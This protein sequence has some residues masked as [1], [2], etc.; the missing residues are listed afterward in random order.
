[1]KIVYSDDQRLHAPRY[2]MSAGDMSP[3]FE[4]PSRADMVLERVRSQNFGEVVGVQ[5]YSLDHI[6]RVHSESYVNFLQNCWCLW[7]K[8]FGPEKDAMPEVF[9]HRGMRQYEPESIEAK[10]GYYAFDVCVGI[11]SG[12]WTAIKTAADVALTGVDIIADGER[13]AFSLC[14]PPGHHASEDLMGGYC[15]INNAAVAAQALRD[16]GFNKVAILDVDYHHGNGTQSIFY[17]RDDIYFAS[18]HGDPEHEYPY[19]LGYADETG[20]AAGAGYNLN[21][22]LPLG[23]T[24]WGNYKEALNQCMQAIKDFGADVI[25]V[26]LGLDTFENDP[27]SSFKI[28][29]D[30]FFEMGALIEA[31]VLPTLFVFEGGYGL[32]ALGVNAVNVLQG[33]ER[34]PST[35]R[36]FC[37]RS[38]SG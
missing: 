6:T 17:A 4:K 29:S 5:R 35:R 14:R 16:K 38:R 22:P 10:L 18:I 3:C 24:D 34:S 32:E 28:R 19:Y 31:A 11:T 12:S 9:P 37:S 13:S 8:K 21:L 23:T 33:F 26:S 25:V 2:Q 36:E 27:I 20:E 1:M 30:E 15:Y 7:E